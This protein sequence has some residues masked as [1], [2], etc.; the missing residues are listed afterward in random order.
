MA[1]ASPKPGVLLFGRTA[2]GDNVP[3]LVGTDGLLAGGGNP[4][5]QNLSTTDSPTFA[6]LHATTVA[7]TGKSSGGSLGS[8]A[9]H[10]SAKP[11]SPAEGDLC[12]FDDANSA[13]WGATISA[14]SSTNHVLARWNG[15]AWTVVGK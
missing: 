7:A 11:A 3:V 6:A 10:F 1:D 15:S 4:F 8:T 13:T 12:N 5:D 2:G 9:I 14:G